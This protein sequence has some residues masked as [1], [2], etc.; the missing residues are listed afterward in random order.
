MYWND[1]LLSFLLLRRM[2]PN[3]PCEEVALSPSPASGVQRDKR[4]LGQ[5][6]ESWG[7]G[8][9]GKSKAHTLQK[10]RSAQWRGERE[11]QWQM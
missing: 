10:L 8:L 11:L 7:S 5:W 9:I 2:L 6:L 4:E 1:R 3:L